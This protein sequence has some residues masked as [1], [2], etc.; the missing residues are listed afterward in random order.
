MGRFSSEWAKGKSVASALSRSNTATSRTIVQ[1]YIQTDALTSLKKWG[2]KVWSSNELGKT[3]AAKKY[4]TYRWLDTKEWR[5]G[6]SGKDNMN[7]SSAMLRRGSTSMTNHLSELGNSPRHRAGIRPALTK[8]DLPQPLGPTIARN[9][10][11][12]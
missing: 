4:F 1:T 8:L 10:A 3:K 2:G 7:Y 12:L 11:Y 6:K 9:L 5:S